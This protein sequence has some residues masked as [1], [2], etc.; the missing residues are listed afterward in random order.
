MYLYDRRLTMN[1]KE[2][3]EIPETEIWRIL[4]KY[5]IPEISNNIP[6]LSHQKKVLLKRLLKRPIFLHQKIYKLIADRRSYE[7]EIRELSAYVWAIKKII[8]LLENYNNPE[9]PKHLLALNHREK[10]R[11]E[12]LQG[13]EIILIKKIDKR[14][15]LGLSSVYTTRD[16][17][18]LSWAIELII[19]LIE[20]NQKNA[21]PESCVNDSGVFLYPPIYNYLDF[22]NSS[23]IELTHLK[24]L[25]YIVIAIRQWA[26]K[27]SPYL[28]R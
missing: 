8:A 6:L 3:L 24:T 15:K 23:E 21:P 19:K 12:R 27:Q 5:D 10:E 7:S 22:L 26:E 20:L 17:L 4:S 16:L 25:A 13:I 1:K 2:L 18:A 9:I 11:I 14:M 28:K